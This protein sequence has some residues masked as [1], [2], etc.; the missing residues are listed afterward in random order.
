MDRSPSSAQGIAQRLEFIKIEDDEELEMLAIDLTDLD[1]EQEGPDAIP[2]IHPNETLDAG[3]L[4]F[5]YV[6]LFSIELHGEKIVPGDHVQFDDKTF[7]YNVRILKDLSN[8]EVFLDGILL[9]RKK[10]LCGFV[11]YSK[12]EI[13]EL[14]FVLRVPDGEMEPTLDQCRTTKPL[15]AALC[16]REIILTN[17]APPAWSSYPSSPEGLIRGYRQLVCRWRLTEKTD[18]SGK[19]VVGGSLKLLSEHESD[20]F[21]R[22]P[23]MSLLNRF[24][25]AKRQRKAVARTHDET[26]QAH[27]REFLEVMDG[28]GVDVLPTWACKKR[29]A[30]VDMTV[31]GDEDVREVKR[32]ITDTLERIGSSDVTIS[33]RETS[34]T[35][36]KRTRTMATM[37]STSKNASSHSLGGEFSPVSQ[38]TIQG[39]MKELGLG[40]AYNLIHTRRGH[41]TFGD[42][43]SGGGGS[44]SGAEQAGLKLNFLL[45]KWDVAYDTLS[46]NFTMFHTEIL[47]KTIHD[48]CT[49][50]WKENYELVD[51]LHISYPCQT[52]SSNHTQPG[53]T[54]AANEAAGYSVGNI[55]ERCM[56]RIV[57]FEQ[58][59]GIVNYNGGV[60]FRAMIRQITDAGYSAKWQISNLSVHGLLSPRKRLIMF[61]A[62]PGEALPPFPKPTHG[63][64]LG[65]RRPKTVQDIINN[66]RGLPRPG[67]SGRSTPKNKQPYRADVP[68]NNC[69]TCNGGKSD[70]HPSGKRSFDMVEL[71]AAQE[72]PPGHLFSGGMTNIRRQ[73]GNAMPPS[74]AKKLFQCVIRSLQE[75]DRRREM[76]RSERTVAP[77]DPVVIED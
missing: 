74:F 41:Y 73:I 23:E 63:L 50:K 51:A 62:C 2:D 26:V 49:N 27:E 29:S 39:G 48:F 44:A 47:C 28:P 76:W 10:D 66:T 21:A 20:D 68:L 34:T 18:V 30:P 9:A 38:R 55:L 33:R 71:A 36:T 11:S 14:V 22:A 69:I 42:I 17:K 32:K 43:G 15:S 7:L 4:P 60:H 61:G 37:F 16:K 54:D 52:H 6:V 56:P 31:E 64:G 19:K 75:S 40:D 24:L 1:D 77:V 5:S 3:E 59:S 53:K 67:E 45:D 8:D 57:T 12:A 13:N 46:L 72:F 58:T 70:L 65:M 35:T 25:D